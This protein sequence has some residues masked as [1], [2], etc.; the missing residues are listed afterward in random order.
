MKN[1][2]FAVVLVVVVGLM[3]WYFLPGF[4]L[5]VVAVDVKSLVADLTRFAKD[6]VVGVQSAAAGH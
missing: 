2:L 6:A 5:E 4:S 3:A 1:L